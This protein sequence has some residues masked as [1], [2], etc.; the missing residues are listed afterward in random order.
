MF[1]RR[2]RGM[3]ED[4]VVAR[5]DPDLSQ[6][7]TRAAV[8]RV[9]TSP[10]ANAVLGGQRLSAE[11]AGCSGPSHFEDLAAASKDGKSGRCCAGRGGNEVDHLAGGLELVALRSGR[12]W[13]AVLGQDCGRNERQQR[14][15][16]AMKKSPLVAKS[17]SPLVAR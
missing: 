5:G 1:S 3:E 17:R 13:A 6:G 14:L 12:L 8:S 16:V 2:S 15:S 10:G 7:A 11:A 9:D 4:Q